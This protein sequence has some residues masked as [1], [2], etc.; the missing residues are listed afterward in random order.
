MIVDGHNACVGYLTRTRMWSRHAELRYSVKTLQ[1]KWRSDISLGEVRTIQPN[2][3]LSMVA[4]DEEI[5][6][7]RRDVL[8]RKES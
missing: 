1:F 2:I 4:D 5:S 7:A 8:D 3:V 6:S